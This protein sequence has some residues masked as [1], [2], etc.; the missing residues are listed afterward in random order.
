ML[1]LVI[2][3]ALA[4]APPPAASEAASA[5]IWSVAG[6]RV[7]LRSEPISFPAVAGVVRLRETRE[8][9]EAGSGLDNGLQYESADRQVF[10]TVYVFYPGLA[11]AGLSAF[12]TDRAIHEQSATVERNGT[13][14]IPLGG[15]AE[16]AILA[17]YSRYRVGLAS[18]AAFMKAGR[19]AVVLRVSGPHERAAD[20][21]AAMDALLAGARFEGDAALR[22]ASPF[23]FANCNAAPTRRA[24]LQRRDAADDA[25]DIQA[26]A[27]IDGAVPLPS[28]HEGTDGDTTSPR[29]GRRWCAPTGLHV[30]ESTYP[31]L[32]RD[33]ADDS[34]GLAVGRT[35]LLVPITDA[36]T[37]LEMVERPDGS[38]Y[39]LL[40]HEIG[41]TTLLG[42]YDGPLADSQIADIVTGADE[43]GTRVRGLVQLR[44]GN[45][46]EI[47]L[48]ADEP[49][50]RGAASR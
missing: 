38:G 41:R 49:S 50:P 1:E 5:Q 32:R 7:R 23:L 22:A 20:V 46:V 27:V 42:S 34:D 19:W 21:A 9:S 29:V 24:R 15:R 35:V 11:D 6:E 45:S 31:V 2:A 10:A 3:A 48:P 18:R 4:V 26:F 40:Y 33:P 36:G 47:E 12:M 25:G 14:V 13:T 17:T 30:G 16:G 8:F 37:T 44:P 43:N 28:A 39:R